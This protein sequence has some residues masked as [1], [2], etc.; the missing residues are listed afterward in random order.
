M[1]FW[2]FLKI[3]I[4]FK[5][6]KKKKIEKKIFFLR[7]WHLNQLRLIVSIKQK[8]LVIGSQCIKKQS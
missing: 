8:M 4:D 2:K 5:N 3:D 7:E 1:F 6:A